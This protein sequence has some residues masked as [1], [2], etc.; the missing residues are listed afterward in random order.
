M[1]RKLSYRRTSSVRLLLV[2]VRIRVRVRDRET[3]SF[4]EDGMSLDRFG[5][6]YR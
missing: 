5:T 4:Y 6:V 3:G 2:R 1:A